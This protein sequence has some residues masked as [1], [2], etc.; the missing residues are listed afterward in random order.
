MSQP[1]ARPRRS[2]VRILTRLF[3][4]RFLENDL[5]SPG[6]DRHDTL[7]ITMS[8]LVSISIFVAFFITTKYLGEYI[9]LP[10]RTAVSALSD[11][12][13]LI[14]FSMTITALVTLLVWDALGLEPR[15][16]AIL[17]PLPLA[18]GEIARAKLSALLLFA[19]GFSVVFNAE[20]SLNRAYT[21]TLA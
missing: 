3:L 10:A 7:A 17:G 16:G 6:S 8:V 12:F 11:R 5:L 4:S 15:D 20:A 21:S 1:P 2:T 9:Q 19:A 13:F 18:T 14:A